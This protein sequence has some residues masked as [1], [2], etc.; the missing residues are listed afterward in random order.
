LNAVTGNVQVL[1]LGGTNILSLIP[2]VPSGTN[3]ATAAQGIKADNAVPTND[4]RY[5]AALTNVVGYVATNDPHYLASLTNEPLF[6]AASGSVIYATTPAYTAAVAQAS[7]A[8]PSNNPNA[9]TNNTVTNAINT[10][11]RYAMTNLPAS[12]ITNAP[13]VTNAA[14]WFN[15]VSTSQISWIEYVPWTSNEYQVVSSQLNLTGAGINPNVTGMY[16]QI[17]DYLGTSAWYN[18][19][20]GY[21]VCTLEPNA[22]WAITPEEGFLHA[23]AAWTGS[24]DNVEGEYNPYADSCTGTI[25]A[26]YVDPYTNTIPHYLTN[27]YTWLA[28]WNP[29]TTN[30][31]VSR[32]GVPQF[33]ISTNGVISGNG[34]GL[35]GITAAQI[36]DSAYQPYSATNW[37][38]NGTVTVSYADGPAIKVTMTNEPT[39]L[40]FAAGYPD[41]GINRVAVN[42]YR[43]TNTS[44]GFVVG[45]VTNP[46]APVLTNWTPAQLIFRTAGTNLPWIGSQIIR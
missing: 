27:T 10:A 12:A 17:A 23:N 41:S 19:S 22:Q 35:T 37:A 8:Y 14:G 44:I 31:N 21:Y 11:L 4:A 39:V 36:T 20:N 5:L 38:V 25:T 7:A 28:G 46:V 40:V 9:F 45:N 34:S 1:Y 29:A 32:A 6:Q 30:W 3:Y 16:A 33:S 26:A 24:F 42:V 13:W 43:G 2:S 18:A 15:I